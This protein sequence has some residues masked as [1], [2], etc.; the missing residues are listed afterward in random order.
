MPVEKNVKVMDIMKKCLMRYLPAIFAVL[1]CLGTV[2]CGDD[3]EPALPYPYNGQEWPAPSP[4]DPSNM[5]LGR[6]EGTGTNDD[7]NN[8]S[9]TLQLRS[10]GTGSL[11]T[12]CKTRI[13]V[14]IFTSYRYESSGV[15]QVN[16]NKGET[17]RIYISS[18]TATSMQLDLSDGPDDLQT[19]YRLTKTE[20]YDGGGSGSG[21][22]ELEEA[23][24]F[25]VRWSRGASSGAGT[26]TTSYETYYKKLSATGKYTLYRTRYGT[27]EIGIASSNG[28]STWGGYRVSSY[29]Y[30]YRDVSTNSSTYYFFN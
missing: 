1:C 26:Y 15:L 8:C 17:Y 24:T 4:S 2:S 16:T 19:T 28:L 20:D 29:S 13:L 18:L 30:L 12:S 27:G 22:A 3:D 11:L 6:W 5:I 21:E 7:G 23:Y 14:R 10:D 9:M 25:V